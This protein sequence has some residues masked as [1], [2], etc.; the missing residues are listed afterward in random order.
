MQRAES[1]NV[2][3]ASLNAKDNAIYTADNWHYLNPTFAKYEG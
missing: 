2:A 3:V 1:G